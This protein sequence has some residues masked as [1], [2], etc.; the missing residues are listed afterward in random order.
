MI[1]NRFFAG[2]ACL[3][4]LVCALVVAAQAQVSVISVTDENKHATKED[5]YHTFEIFIYPI[6]KSQ[7]SKCQATRIHKRWFATAAHCVYQKC[8][9]GCRVEMDLLEQPYSVLASVQH[10]PAG[11]Q[12]KLHVFMHPDYK[13][14]VVT[15]NDIA[16]IKLDLQSASKLFYRRAA[17]SGQPNQQV[18]QAVFQQFLNSHKKAAA[19]YRRVLSPQIPPLLVFDEMNYL[20]DRTISVISIF[21]GVR[22]IKKDPH[23]VYYVKALG[24]AYT[25]DFG[26]RKGM[27]GSGVM[28]NTGELAG[29]IS[30]NFV[31]NTPVTYKGDSRVKPAKVGNFFLFP[32]FNNALRQFLQDTMGS[33]YYQLEIK[34]APRSWKDAST[35]HAT[36]LQAVKQFDAQSAKR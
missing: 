2:V 36:L 11:K 32:A 4:V 10:V 23:K 29:I 30:S 6:D 5:F 15:K 9:N 33:D 28:T 31:F 13:P 8:D 21:N 3:G 16:L 7:P 27:S 1:K 19:Q 18:P 34:E 26:I 22:E 14:T 25:P 20:L 17:A 12:K 24:F 35:S